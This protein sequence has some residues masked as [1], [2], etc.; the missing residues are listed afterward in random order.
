MTNQQL[1]DD[2]NDL[3]DAADNLYRAADIVADIF[4]TKV[5]EPKST[6]NPTP[7]NDAESYLAKATQKIKDFREGT[8]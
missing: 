7:L 3:C 2:L 4:Y 5:R 8:H 6:Y 1:A